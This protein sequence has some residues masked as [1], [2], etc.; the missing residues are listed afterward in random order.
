[1]PAARPV[2]VIVGS[3]RKASFSRRIAEALIARAPPALACRVVERNV[4]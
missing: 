2:A 1:M 4:A 3:L